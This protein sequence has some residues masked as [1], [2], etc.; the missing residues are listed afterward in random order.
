MKSNTLPSFWI[1]YDGLSEEIKQRVKKSFR[2]WMQ[3]PFHPS[4]HFKCI[5]E[6]ERI[7]SVR[8]SLGYGVVGVLDDDTVTWFWVG[9]HD[10]YERFF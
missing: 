5:N 4:L 2:L 8:V 10:N 7:W 3:N 1:A 9:S 6:E